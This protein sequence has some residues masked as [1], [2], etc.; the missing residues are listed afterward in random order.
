MV[1]RTYLLGG[2]YCPRVTELSVV[3][4][5]YGCDSCLRALHSRLRAAIEPITADFELI[6]V[7]DRSPDEAWSTLR[8]IARSDSSARA[9][10]LSRNFGQHAAITAGLAASRGRWVVVMDCDLQDPPE[11]IPELYAKA[12]EGHDIVLCE[13][14]ARRQSLPRRV[15]ARTYFGLAS[16][17]LK[18]DMHGG[19][20]SLS[21]I[22]AKVREAFLSLRDKDRQYLLILLW[23]GFERATIEVEQAERYSGRSSYSFGQLIRVA[24]N[25]IFFQTT[26]LLRWIVFGG[27]V[28]AGLGALLVAYTLIVLA[29]G[30]HLPD[31]TALPILIL[32]LAG[33]IVVSTGVT[34]LYIGRIF[35]Q[36]RDR[37]LFV[38][39]EE[40][41]HRRPASVAEEVTAA[42]WGP[43]PSSTL[44]RAKPPLRS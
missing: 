29:A 14:R 28:L 42:A 5:V 7:D 23:L 12:R 32:L 3:V 19:Y 15:A 16:Y 39:D 30:R 8:D 25:G 37:P 17:L 11:K 33:F 9:L 27:F 18:T 34:G 43:P 22:S 13:R 21:I 6:F 20:T 41:G 4:P 38:V 24:S 31:W 40:I 26:A 10:R 35:D 36:V 1:R 2:C 44:E